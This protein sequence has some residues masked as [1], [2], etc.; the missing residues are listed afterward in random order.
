[1]FTKL[2]QFADDLQGSVLTSLSLSQV[3]QMANFAKGLKSSDFQQVVLSAPTYAHNETL[4]TADGGTKSVVMPDWPAI[5]QA[6]AQFFPDSGASNS[7]NLQLSPPDKQTVQAENAPVLVE[8]G[9]TVSGV[10]AKLTSILKSEGFNVLDPQS[11]DRD[12]YIQ[13]QV[14]YFDPNKGYGT[15][16]VLSKML[17]V[18][19][20]LSGTS[21]PSGAAIVII[22]GSDTA[23]AIMQSS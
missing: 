10:A 5:N 9:S 17:G 12:N 14:Q 4:T 21:P 20:E 23:N 18:L 22:I 15:S 13:T 2:D 1:M 8:N 3:L 19:D 7:V 6:I 11:A 16:L